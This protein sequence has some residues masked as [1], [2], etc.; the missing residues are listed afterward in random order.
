LT[1]YQYI[2]K[3]KKKKKKIMLNPIKI[4][5]V[6]KAI[7]NNVTRYVGVI[8]MTLYSFS[9]INND[10]RNIY[11]LS[12]TDVRGEVKY[13]IDEDNIFK[14]FDTIQSIILYYNNM[15]MAS[16]GEYCI[17]FSLRPGLQTKMILYFEK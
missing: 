8:N 6:H 5:Q 9:V 16:E 10:T 12:I 4:D 3:K 1:I 15:E 11:N 7:Y 2:E 14:I 13:I 17:F